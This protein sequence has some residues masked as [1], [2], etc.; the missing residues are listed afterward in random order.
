MAQQCPSGGATQ[1]AAV[2]SLRL[3]LRRHVHPVALGKHAAALHV[4]SRA[5]RGQPACAQQRARVKTA[6]SHRTSFGASPLDTQRQASPGDKNDSTQ[7]TMLSPVRSKQ[8]GAQ[9]VAAHVGRLLH[10]ASPV[11]AHR[12]IAPTDASSK[13]TSSI[14]ARQRLVRHRPQVVFSPRK[15]QCSPPDVGDTSAMQPDVTSS[16]AVS[17]RIGAHDSRL[18]GT[19]AIEPGA[20]VHVIFETDSCARKRSHQSG[21]T[22]KPMTKPK[23]KK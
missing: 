19:I 14:S 6:E 5:G 12:S 15:R 17:A 9:R 3:S 23:P 4:H 11:S 21:T 8:Y 16:R 18:Q 13:Q 22:M 2:S 1:S 10:E 20:D 7:L